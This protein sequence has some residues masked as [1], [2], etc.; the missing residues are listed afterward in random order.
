MKW[1]KF[2]QKSKVKQSKVGKFEEILSRFGKNYD[3]EILYD[4]YAIDFPMGNISVSLIDTHDILAAIMSKKHGFPIF[5]VLGKN[6]EDACKQ[7]VET[8]LNDCILQLPDSRQSNGIF[9]KLPTTLE[10]LEIFID[11]TPS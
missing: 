11:L 7:Y 8:I 9:L 10:E 3:L 4:R 6:K 1:Y 5:R 2:F